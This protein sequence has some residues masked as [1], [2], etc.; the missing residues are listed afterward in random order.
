MVIA[1]LVPPTRVA[2]R[3]ATEALVRLAEPYPSVVPDRVAIVPED[4]SGMLAFRLVTVKLSM[5]ALVD[6]SVVIVELVAVSV[7]MLELVAVSVVMTELVAFKL[8]ILELVAPRR[9]AV[10]LATEAL[11]KLAEP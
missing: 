2:V 4:G 7:V 9:V 5:V 6:F 3:L 11:V 1:P 10:R 8:V